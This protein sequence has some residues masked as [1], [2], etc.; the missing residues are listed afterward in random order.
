MSAAGLPGCRERERER[1][2]GGGGGGGCCDDTALDR[3]AKHGNVCGWGGYRAEG[4]GMTG[5]G[6]KTEIAQGDVYTRGATSPSQ[7]ERALD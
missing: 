1:E 3:A 5:G 6:I 7:S 2:G 4:A